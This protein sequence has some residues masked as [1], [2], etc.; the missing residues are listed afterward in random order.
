MIG[1]LWPNGTKG[2]GKTKLL[3]VIAEL[4]YLGQMLQ[5]GG[6]LA[7]L[8]DLADYGATLCFDDA[9]H[10]MDV[11]KGDPDKRT[12][13]LA[14]NRKGSWITVKEPDTHGAWKTRY[15]QTFCPRLF[16]AIRLPDP[17]ARQSHYYCAAAAH[18][19]PRQSQRRSRWSPGLAVSSGP[20][21]Q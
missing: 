16:S 12:L 17:C 2:S 15:V 6:T 21:D 19:Q 13:L 3:T 4:A 7:T 20:A 18:G 5:A 11:K 10:V 9:E 14:G 1:Y 8:R